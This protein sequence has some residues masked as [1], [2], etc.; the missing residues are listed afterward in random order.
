MRVRGK[1]FEI[2]RIG[3]EHG[4]S[5]FGHSHDQ[6]IHDGPSPSASSQEGR[7][8]GQCFSNVFENVAGLE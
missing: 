2:I 1:S 7:A 8:P 5:G 3:S 6:C 4:P